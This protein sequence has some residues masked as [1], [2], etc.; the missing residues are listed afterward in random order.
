[1]ATLIFD[2][3]TVGEDFAALD[4]TTKESLTRWIKRESGGEDEY[5]AALKDLEDGLGFS[6]LTGQIVAIGVL[7]AERQ[8]S[9][10]YYQPADANDT[11]FEEGS[12]KFE[13]LSEKA[14]L[15][16]FWEI[17]TKYDTFVTFNG[18]QFDVPFLMVRSAVHGVKPTK[19][20]LANRYLQYQPYNAKHVDLLDQ[21]SFYGV[22]RRKGSLHLWTRAFGIESPKAQGVTGDD[23]QG[24]Y[25]EGKYQ[26][27]ARYNARDLV[28]TLALYERYRGY[29]VFPEK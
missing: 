18:R 10:V 14:M 22:M 13:A 3:E 7:D 16:K 28:A 15:E 6:P 25:K 4:E 8:K 21:L 9:A 20:L 17:A 24:L 23:V 11:D 5:Q 19:N 12:A 2:I 1:M 27:I 26:T 29:F